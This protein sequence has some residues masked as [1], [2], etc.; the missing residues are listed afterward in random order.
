[1]IADL[2]SSLFP[3][4]TEFIERQ[5]SYLVNETLKVSFQQPSYKN[6]VSISKLALSNADPEHADI[7]FVQEEFT[8]PDAF[9]I[10]CESKGI[11]IFT[12]TP[13]AGLFALHLLKQILDFTPKE[14]PCF[15]INDL[16]F[17]K[18]RGFMLDVSR[19]KVPTMESIFEF[20][21]LL[22]ILRFN[23]FQ[24]YIEHTF[25]FQNH[26]DVWKD[27]SPLS[28]EE[29]QKIDHYCTDRF[30]DLVPNLNSFGHFERWLRHKPYKNLAECPDGFHREEPFMVRDHGSVLKPNQESLEFI[31]Y[32]YQ[33]YLPNFSSAKFNVGLDEPWELGQGWSKSIVEKEGKHKVYLNY[34]SG[35]LNLVEKRGKSMEFWADVLLEKPENACNL[36]VSASPVIWGYEPE[37]P[38][39]EQAKILASSGLRYSLAPGTANWRSF[40]GRWDTVRQNIADAC[41]VAKA[42]NA[43]GILLTSWGDCGNH[44]PWAT[45]YPPLFLG[46]QL[47]WNGEGLNDE[48]IGS[49][50]DNLAF[51]KT[52]YG[53]GINFIHLACLDQIMDFKLPNNSLPWFALFSA[54]PDKL[55]E[56]L[57]EHTTLDQ[58]MKGL[59]WLEQLN[60]KTFSSTIDSPAHHAKVEWRLGIE[61]SKI[62]TQRAI[63]LIDPSTNYPDTSKNY[64]Q[65][66]ENFQSTWLLRARRGGLAE[67]IQL[68]KN[69]LPIAKSF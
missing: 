8:N 45:I 4:P 42:H 43:E 23:E 47:A 41:R 38:F 66:L 61:L 40:S 68:L 10:L 12:S 48:D 60:E 15:E 55:P 53:L 39:K 49:A 11:T 24:L 7:C 31:D 51:K 22:S 67:A 5:G 33:E 14:I 19:C 29:I 69:A 13:R 63:S 18:R 58:M 6:L 32:L 30:I 64:N 36:P 17:L 50:V 56:H 25:A 27:S 2:K 1:M 54:Q 21:D 44:Q 3:T 37:H 28:G 20:I 34:L 65:V 46:A 16:P 62:G 57:L 35:I 9:K 26:R 59:A 52:R